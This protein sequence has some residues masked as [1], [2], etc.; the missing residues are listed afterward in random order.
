[1]VARKTD[2]YW[3]ALDYS[4]DGIVSLTETCHARLDGDLCKVCR[5]ESERANADPHWIDIDILDL[6]PGAIGST[7]VDVEILRRDL[8]SALRPY[9]PPT[10]VGRVR[11]A[12]QD[13]YVETEFVSMRTP[14]VHQVFSS[15]G[16]YNRHRLCP[17]C[18]KYSNAIYRGRD[19]IMRRDVAGKMCVVDKSGSL[20]LH[21]SLAEKLHL[22]DRK[23][24]PDL[25]L[26][27]IRI[28]DK[29]EDGDTLPGDEGW[30]GTFRPQRYHP[31][32]L[33]IAKDTGI[34]SAAYRAEIG[35]RKGGLKTGKPARKKAPKSARMSPRKPGKK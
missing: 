22:R 4:I 18:G 11:Y 17:V 35:K 21:P 32:Y 24:W 23:R 27:K 9:A 26:Y 33:G 19:A 34:W 5:Q 12:V 20:I 30:D 29:P 28:I 15:R 25:R 3:L 31:L 14:Y 1:M 13:G 8:W 10:I 6:P 7:I 2:T 16:K